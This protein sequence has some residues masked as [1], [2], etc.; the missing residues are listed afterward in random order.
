MSERLSH[1]QIAEIIEGAADAKVL[2]LDASIRS[3][4]TPA[5]AIAKHTG[6][7]VA[8]H[9]VCCNEYG[10]VTGATAGL[11]ITDIRQELHSLRASL[12]QVKSKGL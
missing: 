12:E 3:L 6:E 1:A 2:N 9:I 7:E 5:A 10:L 4:I 11:D 8:L